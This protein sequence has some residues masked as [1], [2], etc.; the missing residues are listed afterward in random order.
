[1]T[2][3][4]VSVA[5]MIL[6]EDGV[7]DLAAP[8][9]RWLPEFA[10]PMVLDDPSRN[11]SAKRPATRPITIFDLLTHRSGLT[12]A[13]E[14]KGDLADNLAK[15]AADVHAEVDRDIWLGRLASLPLVANPNSK[16]QYGLST[17][18]LGILIERAAGSPLGCFLE[19]RIFSHL[20]MQ[21]TFF[22]VP[23]EKLPRLT[24]A[25]EQNADGTVTVLDRTIDSKWSKPAKFC[26]G[27]GGLVSTIDDFLSF[28][29]FLLNGTSQEGRTLLSPDALLA[30]R[31]N[32][33]TAD[34]RRVPAF[35][36]PFFAGQGFGLGLAIVD[37]ETA[38]S[39]V[40]GFGR[41]GDFWWDGSFGTSWLA[42]PSDGHV[43]LYFTQF[44]ANRAIRPAPA[45][46][47]HQAA[48]RL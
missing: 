35:G 31:G 18:V 6:A 46:L 44:R 23:P 1:M 28:A 38:Q 48:A 10:S 16:F 47:F 14:F 17:D 2:K 34:Q 15:V 5:A 8:I 42:S 9:A 19:E 20:G 41:T 33:L 27:G 40:I 29:R 39:E 30:M 4:V 22:C 32:T 36:R 11:D 45:V 3:P 13:Y 7:L 26:G 24:D 21:D 37:D 43:S 25:V 12:Y